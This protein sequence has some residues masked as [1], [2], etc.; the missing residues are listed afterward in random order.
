MSETSIESAARA[1]SFP[2]RFARH[3]L[4]VAGAIV[5]AIIVIAVVLGPLFLPFDPNQIEMGDRNQPPSLAHLMGTD[6][7]GR[8]QFARVL[9]GGRLTLTVALAAVAF[10]LV[11]GVLIGAIAG[12]TGKVV[13][14]VLMR[15]VDVFYSIPALFVVI[16]LVTLIGSGFWSIV[17]AIAAFSWMNTARLVRAGFLTLKEREFVEAARGIGAGH[18]RIAVRHIL[19]GTVGPIVVTATIGIATAILVE[20]ALSFLGLGFQPPQATWGG[21]LFEAQRAVVNQGMWWRGLFPGL[22]IF[23]VVLAV[24]YVGDGLSDAL[25]PRRRVR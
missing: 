9:D 4:G 12:Y 7:L 13:D 22:M 1:D 24:N 14:N 20:S 11:A 23:L 10:S 15:G 5:L 19:P 16:L 2:A 25:D 18:L 3:R 8:D 21:M 6:D 17:I